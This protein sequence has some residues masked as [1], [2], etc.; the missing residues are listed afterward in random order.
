MQSLNATKF[1]VGV[2]AISI[3]RNQSIVIPFAKE[4]AT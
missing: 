3:L 4:A 1:S 2:I